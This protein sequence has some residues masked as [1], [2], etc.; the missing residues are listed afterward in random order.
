MKFILILISFVIALQLQAQDTPEKLIKEF[1][2]VYETDRGEAVRAIYKT[3]K[4]TDRIKDDIE[5]IVNGVN[6]F[7]T[8]FMGEYYGNEL[9][10]KKSM[11]DSFVL[12]SYF[13]KYDR[14]PIR[15]TFKF[16]KPDNKWMV[17]AFK[18]DDS[19]S[20]EIDEAA[21]LYYLNLD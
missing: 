19:F 9:I 15:F 6:G 1:F 4:W 8:D 18:Y 13:V 12:Y 10:V 2:E 7:T 16:Y 17:Y 11:S 14:Q 20:S 5:K 21:K 3:N